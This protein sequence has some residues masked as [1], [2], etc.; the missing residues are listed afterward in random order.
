M[1][2]ERDISGYIRKLAGFYPVV[3]VTGPRQSGK[4]T[5]IR[6]LYPGYA[7]FNLESRDVRDLIAADPRAFVDYSGKTMSSVAAHYADP[8]WLSHGGE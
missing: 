5:L 7:Y 6:Q 4:T 1:F 2:I 8:L 3:T